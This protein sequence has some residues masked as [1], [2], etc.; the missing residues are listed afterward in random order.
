MTRGFSTIDTLNKGAGVWIPGTRVRSPPDYAHWNTADH[1]VGQSTNVRDAVSTKSYYSE[2]KYKTDFE[3]WRGN[4]QFEREK[5]EIS[6]PP[7]DS[8]PVD[9]KTSDSKAPATE[10]TPDGE[11]IRR[12]NTSNRLFSI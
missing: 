7:L 4:I 3:I 10:S 9:A 12:K 1:Y 11:K 5:I 8:T 2:E 6:Q